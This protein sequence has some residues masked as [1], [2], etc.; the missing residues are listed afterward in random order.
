MMLRKAVMQSVGVLL[1]PCR[2]RER[3]RAEKNGQTRQFVNL[4][5][6]ISPITG[7]RFLYASHTFCRNVCQPII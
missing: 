3:R 2:Q 4:P 1:R 5:I 7:A 6:A